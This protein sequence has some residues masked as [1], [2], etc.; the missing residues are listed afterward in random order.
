MNGRHL[1]TIVRL[2]IQRSV[3][4]RKG[5]GFDPGPLLAVGEAAIGPQGISGLHDGAHVLDVHHAAHPVGRGGGKRSLSMGFTAHYDL[6]RARFGEFPTGVG[7][8]N[9]I[10]EHD[11]RLLIEDLA[12]RVVVRSADGDVVLS[13]AR[14]AAPCREFTS[15]LLGEDEVLDRDLLA[16]DLTFLSDGMRG[17]ILDPGAVVRPMVVRLGDEVIARD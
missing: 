8:E 13:S 16:D 4:K 2:Q 12:G 11:T 5:E 9:V 10:V 1:G 14:V 6:I 17:F 3:L 15:F 7:G